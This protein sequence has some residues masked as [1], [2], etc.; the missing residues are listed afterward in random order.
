M[1]NESQLNSIKNILFVFLFVLVMY[2]L[3]ELSG[4]LVPLAL[5]ILIALMFQPLVGFLQRF[6]APKWLIFPTVTLITLLVVFA[7]YS[8]LN[9]AIQSIIENQDFL[10]EK[11]NMRIKNVVVWINTNFGTAFSTA[12][13]KINLEYLINEYGLPATIP[14]LANLLSSLSGSFVMFFLYYVV[15][16]IGLADYDL[17]IAHVKGDTDSRLIEN[18]SRIQGSI[19]SYLM[20]KMLIS[21]LT[22]IL[23]YLTCLFFDLN[24]AFFFGF[25]AFLLNFIPSIGSIIATIPPVLMAFIQFDTF[26]PVIFLL[27]ILSSIQMVMGNLVE[28]IIT[29][30]RLKLNTL[31]VIF[32]LVFWG[33]IWGLAGMII[34]IP[35][36]VLLKLIFEHFP[37]TQIF[38]RIMGSPE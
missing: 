21:L 23:V 26:Q 4:I 13:K 12:D 6:K 25:I 16:L 3:K 2:L 33:Y 11:L 19:L 15:L 9:E 36:L 38:A 14:A 8:I 10:V 20:I 7:V 28:P 30:D 1:N 31:T 5:A 29:G 24:F 32:G 17:Y 27:L 34:S 22:G 37:D 18:M 35:L